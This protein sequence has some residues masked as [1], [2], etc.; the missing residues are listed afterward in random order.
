MK[1]LF[2][3]CS[4]GLGHATRDIPLMRGILEAK[5]SLTVVGKGRS[6]ELLKGELGD[7]CRYVSMS[8]Y[9]SVYSKKDFSVAK[10]FRLLIER[11]KDFLSLSGTVLKSENS[12][13]IMPFFPRYFILK[14]SSTSEESVVK[15]LISFSIFDILFS[16]L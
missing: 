6:L 1:I 7:R 5:H 15:M 12:E 3:V 10:F 11:P 4:W 9:S 16:I 8:D 2:A 14:F 13:V